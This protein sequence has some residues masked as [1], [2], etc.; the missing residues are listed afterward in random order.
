M[1]EVIHTS[2]IK[3]V[4]DE[5]PVRRAFIE[6]FEEPY[7]YG[8][9]GGIAAFYGITPQTEYPATLDHIIGGVGG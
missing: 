8:V 6:N 3:I 5:G 7:Y 9:H 1:G 4:K 2:R